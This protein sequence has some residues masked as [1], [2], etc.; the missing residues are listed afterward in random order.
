MPRS[1]LTHWQHGPTGSTGQWDAH[2]R[3]PGVPL[4]VDIQKR[5]GRNRIVYNKAAGI[6]PEGLPLGNGDLAAMT[7]QPPNM[8]CWGLTKSDVRDLR[9]PVIPW[10][11]H[12]TINQ[13]FQKQGNHLLTDQ[14]NEEEW[15]FRTYFPCFLPAGGLWFS[16]TQPDE[17]AVKKQ[18]LDLYNAAH[19]LELTNG[20]RVESFVYADGNVLA[21]RFSGMAGRRVKMHL[22]PEAAPREHGGEGDPVTAAAIRKEVFRRIKRQWLSSQTT[23]QLDYAD[24]NRTLLVVQV[25]GAKLEIPADDAEAAT[26]CFEEPVADV[27]LTIVTA[28]EGAFLKRRA[29][30]LLETAWQRNFDRLRY[31]HHNIWHERWS[32]SVVQLPE[33]ILEALW[34]HAIYTMAS[35]SR[36]AFPAPLMS[37]WNLRLDQPYGGDYHNNINSQ[38]CYWPLLAA[39]HCDLVEPYLRHFWSVMPEMEMETR[40]VWDKPGIKIPFASIGRGIDHWGVG[41]WRYE[42][43]VSAWLAQIAWWHYE[44][45]GDRAQL[46]RTGWPIIRGVAEFYMA[47]LETDPATGKLSLPL[48]KLCEDTMFNVVPSQRLVRDAGTDLT[49]VYGHLRDAAQAADVLG[50]TDDAIRYRQALANLNPL[51]MANGEFTLAHGVPLDVPVS[52]PYQLI[53]IYPTGL[54]T[55]LGPATLAPIARRTLENIWRCSSRVTVGQPDQGRLRWNDDLSMGWIGVTRAWMGDG[56]GAL[57]ALL[58]G[59]VTSTLKTNG[60]LTE[61]SRAPGE[62]AAM[63][64]MQNQLCGLANGVNEMLLQSHSGV[65][66]VFPALPSS[67]KDA[68][69]VQLRA[70]PGVLVSAQRKNGS[71]RWVVLS[72]AQAQQVKLRNP[73]PEETIDAIALLDPATDGSSL[74]LTLD[75]EGNF[76]LSLVADQSLLLALQADLP[77]GLELDAP[78][79]DGAE[80]WSFT[81]P[82]R[83]RP[84]D[85]EPDG[86]WTSWWGKP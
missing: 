5:I 33:R 75:E 82:I 48:T 41:Y 24:G 34:C 50:H 56:D 71:T 6:W 19:T 67:W 58:N 45:T 17:L 60:F 59:W 25:R 61:Q 57:D 10:T 43:F 78:E 42:L 79:D 84:D 52:H 85:P 83:L 72:T 81:G 73:W 51:P 55:Q 8:L 1:I 63:G 32:R 68:G 23:L 38:M 18:T 3:Y 53:P 46:Q 69:F 22:G 80:P 12:E 14:I 77:D 54:V 40:R 70:R 36:G 64:W 27:M 9:H 47:Y 37:A 74:P 65:I 28:R 16:A 86:T 2:C 26:L 39:N 44:F 35:S 21:L 76:N 49:A 4:A 13:I 11:K 31:D 62:R 7:F 66:H 29:S 15:D 30:L 20:G